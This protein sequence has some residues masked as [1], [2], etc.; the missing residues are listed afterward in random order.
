[1][2]TV[3]LQNIPSDTYSNGKPFQFDGKAA[4]L[5]SESGLLIQLEK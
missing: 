5:R 1:L 3:G 2:R 4:T